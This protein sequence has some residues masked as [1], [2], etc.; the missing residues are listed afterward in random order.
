MSDDK[1]GNDEIKKL[2]D[3]ADYQRQVGDKGTCITHYRKV[4]RSE[5]S[6][7]R[8]L[9]GLG[10]IGMEGYPSKRR[11]YTDAIVYFKKVLEIDPNN[12][13][14]INYMQKTFKLNNKHKE[15][16]EFLEKKIKNNPDNADAW[17]NL[18]WSYQM[19]S[20]PMENQTTLNK[21]KECYDNARE[22]ESKGRL[23]KKL[24]ELEEDETNS[25]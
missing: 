1:I 21:A 7:L 12:A 24:K 25:N 22:I 2:L 6:N 5:P 13:D 20:A 3:Q 17:N 9:L 23:L 4:I 11:G 10:I 16:V 8:A 15:M 19:L 14:A 18:G